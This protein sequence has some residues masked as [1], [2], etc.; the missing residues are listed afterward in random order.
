MGMSRVITTSRI[1][2]VTFLDVLRLGPAL[3]TTCTILTGIFLHPA[4]F[5]WT[6]AILAALVMYLVYTDAYLYNYF[7]DTEE[8]RINGKYNPVLDDQYKRLITAYL[9]ISVAMAIG[10]S[11]LY[12]N[13]VALL[14]TLVYLAFGLAY[15]NHAI[16]LK[17]KF[18]VKNLVPCVSF[19][20]ML[21]IM[22][23]SL[24]GEIALIDIV[25]ASY[26]SI[27]S[28]LGSSAR[29]LFDVK[30]D[31]KAGVRTMPVVFGIRG[32]GH[33]FLAF[34]IVQFLLITVPVALGYISQI[35]LLL[36]VAIP[37]R[38][39]LTYHVYRHDLERIN[40]K[41]VP[42]VILATVGTAATVLVANG[43]L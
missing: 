41:A 6:T 22:T 29:D 40:P 32:T 31:R 14:F 8:D 5:E 35:Y 2:L 10:I 36:L 1:K 42:G 11:L 21:F 18:F 7:T 37:L 24:T 30:G 25:V 19:G 15:S 38:L 33:Y 34:T 23:G 20:T 12:L 17:K 43:F 13:T 9:P 26:Y 27:F 28:L 16:R 4:A 3:T 39:Q